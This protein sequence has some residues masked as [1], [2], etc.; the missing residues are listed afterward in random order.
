MWQKENVNICTHY[1]KHIK[2]MRYKNVLIVK[3]KEFLNMNQ[4]QLKKKAIEEKKR[5]ESKKSF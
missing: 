2:N 4:C 5:N 3:N 1:L